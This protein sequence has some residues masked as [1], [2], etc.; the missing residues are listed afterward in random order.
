[1]NESWAQEGTAVPA[2]RATADEAPSAGVLL[3]CAR[4]AAGMHVAALAVSLKVPVRKLEALEQDRWSELSD[5]VFVRGLASSVCRTLKVDP[6][7]VLERLPQTTAPRLSKIGEGLNTRFH[8]ASEAATPAWRQQLTRPVS[9]AVFALLLGALVLVL[10]PYAQ[11]AGFTMIDAGS[12]AAASTPQMLLSEPA[13]LI[14]SGSGASPPAHVAPRADTQD[15]PASLPSSAATVVMTSTPATATPG[16][17]AAG[18]PELPL[19]DDP[20]ATPVSGIIVFRASSPSW[21]EVT[22]AKGVVAVRRV[23]GAGEA[24]GASGALPLQVVIGRVNATEVHVR[25]K[26]FDLRPVS[27]DNV[28]R[29]EVK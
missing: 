12:R 19:A 22:D 3:R 11:Q 14:E 17:A 26:P 29:F 25:G 28:A 5:A 15:T 23:L 27:R 2:S 9:L 7:P 10:L 6:R 21:V 20:A 24:A 13:P 18:L 16:L 1:M 8:A 4:E